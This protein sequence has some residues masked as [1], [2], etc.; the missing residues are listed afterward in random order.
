[1]AASIAKI[2]KYTKSITVDG[3]NAIQ[4]EIDMYIIYHV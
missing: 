1:M 2:Y 3:N 4:V